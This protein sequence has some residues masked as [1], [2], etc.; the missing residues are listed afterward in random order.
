MSV[1]MT[2]RMAKRKIELAEMA[3]QYVRQHGMLDDGFFSMVRDYS[4]KNPMFAGLEGK[5][6]ASAK[7]KGSVQPP[8]DIVWK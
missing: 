2:R 3:G 5:Y 7:P 6:G 8:N 1:E 4:A